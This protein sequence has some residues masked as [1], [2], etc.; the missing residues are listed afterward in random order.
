MAYNIGAKI[1]IDGEAEFRR[2]IKSIDAEYKALTAQIEAQTAA[3]GKGATAEEKAEANAQAL[4][5]Q[6]E[7]LE[8]R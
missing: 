4:R 1:G 2:Q 7:L 6:K 8:Q 5:R 3:L